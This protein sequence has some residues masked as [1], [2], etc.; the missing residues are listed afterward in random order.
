MNAARD[1]ASGVSSGLA[2]FLEAVL[3]QL[4]FTLFSQLV[5]LH[6]FL[7]ALCHTSLSRLLGH[8]LYAAW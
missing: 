1:T 3:L 7:L 4:L 5:R 6:V 8:H 2:T